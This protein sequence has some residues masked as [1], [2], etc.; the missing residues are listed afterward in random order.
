MSDGHE[1]LT[2]HFELERLPTSASWKL[3]G[4]GLDPT[5]LTLGEAQIDRRK[6][7]WSELTIVW[8]SDEDPPAGNA[9][10]EVQARQPARERPKTKGWLAEHG[11]L[12]ALAA[13]IV[14]LFGSGGVGGCQLNQKLKDLDSQK[15]ALEKELAANTRQIESAK[16]VLIEAGGCGAIT[17]RDDMRDVAEQCAAGMLELERDFTSLKQQHQQSELAKEET[18]GL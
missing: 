16:V 7:T 18:R 11:G 4:V 3:L 12:A 17:D 8:E 1:D 5:R 15:I 6:W 13:L 2:L 10:L 9:K 14:A